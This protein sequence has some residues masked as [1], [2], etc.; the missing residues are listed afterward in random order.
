MLCLHN[1]AYKSLWTKT[2]QKGNNLLHK[3]RLLNRARVDESDSTPFPPAS[4]SDLG[5]GMSNFPISNREKQQHGLSQ[6]SRRV[7]T[8]NSTKKQLFS[9]LL[10]IGL[11][12]VFY[13]G[14]NGKIFWPFEDLKKVHRIYIFVATSVWPMP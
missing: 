11:P 4:Q 3:T 6:G 13:E 8:W 14:E 12:A 1:V 7:L 2:N 10:F 5:D 9:C